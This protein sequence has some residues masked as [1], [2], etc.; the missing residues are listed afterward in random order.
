MWSHYICSWGW[1]A[2]NILIPPPSVTTRMTTHS[3]PTSL[4]QYD[5]RRGGDVRIAVVPLD[6]RILYALRQRGLCPHASELILV[7]SSP[8]TL[9]N[10]TV[11]GLGRILLWMVHAACADVYVERGDMLT[12]SFRGRKVLLTMKS[13]V[14]G[15]S[16]KM[17]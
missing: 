8:L 11:E 6:T 15:G 7:H 5:R 17:R 16:K 3:T 12:I 9:P 14:N 13:V 2:V 4:S 1:V 10:N